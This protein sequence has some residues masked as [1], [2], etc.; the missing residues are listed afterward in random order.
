M[1][2]KTK[3]ELIL[4]PQEKDDLENAIWLETR[5]CLEMLKK[6]EG[7]KEEK[8]ETNRMIKSLDRVISQLLQ[9]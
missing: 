8:K 3:I 1:K 5:E 9:Q 4:T 2:T 6:E 7:E